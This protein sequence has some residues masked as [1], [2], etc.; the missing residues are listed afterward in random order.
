MATGLRYSAAAAGAERPVKAAQMP[1]DAA[2]ARRVFVVLG[3]VMG[4]S[5]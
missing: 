3:F 2:N 4:S 5:S 1:I